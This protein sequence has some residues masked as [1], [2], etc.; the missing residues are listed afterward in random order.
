M[1]QLLTLPAAVTFLIEYPRPRVAV[2]KKVKFSITPCG[3]SCFFFSQY[4]CAC[5]CERILVADNKNSETCGSKSRSRL[6][7]P[8]RGVHIRAFS[9][10]SRT[11]SRANKWCPYVHAD[12]PECAERALASHLRDSCADDRVFAAHIRDRRVVRGCSRHWSSRISYVAYV[13][14]TSLASLRLLTQVPPRPLPNR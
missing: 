13:M 6:S 1:G 2:K 7:M 14:C 4:V 11:A 8:G 10:R 9:F 5:Q 3:P 12:D